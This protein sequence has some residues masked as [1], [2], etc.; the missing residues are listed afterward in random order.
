[1]SR[2]IS[3][4]DIDAAL[5]RADQFEA[6]FRVLLEFGLFSKDATT[7]AATPV[8]GFLTEGRKLARDAKVDEAAEKLDHAELAL[9]KALQTPAA[10]AQAPAASARMPISQTAVVDA[11]LRN[12]G[13]GSII[14]RFIAACI[15]S[16]TPHIARSHH[17]LDNARLTIHLL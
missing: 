2:A 13:D 11:T 14:R 1:M 12:I 3:D 17:V 7:A 10:I 4:A 9:Q 16:R 8:L 5:A 15:A 6:R